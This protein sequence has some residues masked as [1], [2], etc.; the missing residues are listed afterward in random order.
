MTDEMTDLVQ[1]L[2]DAWNSHDVERVMALYAPDYHEEDVG[3]PGP[4][5]GLDS[6][7]RS[8]RRYMTAFPDLHLTVDDLL[9]Q[10]N[11][12]SFLWTLSGTHRGGLM[13]IPPSG[14]PVRVR[15][16]TLLTVEGGKIARNVRIW[17]M[18]GMLR[19]IGLLPDL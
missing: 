12:A 2:V 7:R 3:Q 9:V 4:S 17:D 13:N 19:A 16:S 1:R 15:G 6:V 8:V 10:G 14:R 11:R 18:A 5:R